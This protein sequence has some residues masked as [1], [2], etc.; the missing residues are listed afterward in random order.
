MKGLI[1]RFRRSA[2]VIAVFV[3]CCLSLANN[4][5]A[6]PPEP[7]AASA[8]GDIAQAVVFGA[9]AVY[10]AWGIFRKKSP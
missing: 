1:I 2:A 5:L 8:G 7:G 4:A 9:I 6:D 3:F 10:G